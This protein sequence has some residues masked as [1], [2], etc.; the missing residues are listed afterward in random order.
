M[1][2]IGIP[3]QYACFSCRKSFKRPQFSGSTNRFMTS[4]Q[5][6]AQYGE[7]R[8]FQAKRDYRC[9]DCAGLAHFMG[10][11]F[12]APKKGDIRAWRKVQKFIESGKTFYRGVRQD[13]T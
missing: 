8:E 5:Q 11:D 3:M 7:A 12:K 2:S 1:K 13:A 4:D 6:K 9:P 10:Q